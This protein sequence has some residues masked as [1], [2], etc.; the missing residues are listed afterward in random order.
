MPAVDIDTTVYL[1][2]S[3]ESLV[4]NCNTQ[5][6]QMDLNSEFCES[7]ECLLKENVPN[8]IVFSNGFDTSTPKAMLRKPVS[9]ELSSEQKR[10]PAFNI[11]PSETRRKIIMHTEKKMDF[12]KKK[13][14]RD[15]N[16]AKYAKEEHE[17]NMKHKQ[18]LHELEIKYKKEMYELMLQ[19]CR[20]DIEKAKLELNKLSPA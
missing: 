2:L 4:E 5:D 9:K 14:L 20:Y 11:T 17:M 7:E 18:E 10:K 6:N 19:K 13:E 3:Q 1:D 15:L 8:N 12:L 16:L